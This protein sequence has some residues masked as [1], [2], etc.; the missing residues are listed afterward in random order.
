MRLPMVCMAA[1]NRVGHEIPDGGGNRILGLHFCDPFGVVIAQG[2]EETILIG[3]V[4][5]SRIE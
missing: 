4:D 1:V 2:Q 3:E 5:V